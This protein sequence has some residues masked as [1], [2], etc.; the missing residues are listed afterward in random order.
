MQMSSISIF[1]GGS[2]VIAP[3]AVFLRY[4]LK[5]SPKVAST[6]QE[7]LDLFEDRCALL[8]EDPPLTSP[9]EVSERFTVAA[10]SELV[11]VNA[12]STELS[13][14]AEAYLVYRIQPARGLHKKQLWES[15]FGRYCRPRRGRDKRSAACEPPWST[16]KR[17]Q[18][19]V[20]RLV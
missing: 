4:L 3:L 12:S 1:A 8:E 10:S 7:L 15:P 13:T 17:I 9:N 6:S 20:T 14:S 19:L 5:Q 18:H 11:P 16:R 2:A